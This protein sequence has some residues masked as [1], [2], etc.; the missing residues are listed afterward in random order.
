MNT[1]TGTWKAGRILLDDVADWPEGARVEVS[2]VESEAEPL[3]MREADWPTDPQGIAEL[4]AHMDDCEPVVMTPE[5][6]ADIEAWR[7]KIKEYTI[8]KMNKDIDE[9]FP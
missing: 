3:G 5:E 6:E 2:L 8:A 4:L 1:I 9:L 7:Q